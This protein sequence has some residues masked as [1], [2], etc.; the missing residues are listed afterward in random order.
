MTQKKNRDVSWPMFSNTT[1]E[2]VVSGFMCMIDWEC[3]L[4]MASGGNIIYPSVEDHKRCHPCWEECGIVEV[5]VR[6]KRIV[7]N[8]KVV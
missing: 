4:G 2:P 8:S 5:E 1:D 3:E 6:F 7:S